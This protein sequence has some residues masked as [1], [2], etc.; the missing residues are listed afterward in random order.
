MFEVITLGPL[1]I[2]PIKLII[3][4][5]FIIGYFVASQL[6]DNIRKKNSEDPQAVARRRKMEE[7]Y[8]N[9]MKIDKENEAVRYAYNHMEGY[10]D[11]QHESDKLDE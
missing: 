2:Q 11:S 8:N 6:Y 3:L 1:E 5:V 4:A 9:Q 10:A 7:E